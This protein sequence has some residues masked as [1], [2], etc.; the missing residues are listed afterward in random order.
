MAQ[1]SVFNGKIV[2]NFCHQ[3]AT[4]VW[5]FFNS[6]GADNGTAHIRHLCK[7]LTILSCHRC[8]IFSNVDCINSISYRLDT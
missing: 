2:I 5:L 7:K 3:L 8:L 1:E 6:F 4:N